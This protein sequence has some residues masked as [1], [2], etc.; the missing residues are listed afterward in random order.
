ML[1]CSKARYY[2]PT[3]G[4]FVSEDPVGYDSWINF[5]AYGE[6]SPVTNTDPS[7]QQ[8][9]PSGHPICYTNC[10]GGNLGDWNTAGEHACQIVN[11]PECQ[12]VL[13]QQ[14]ILGCMRN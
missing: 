4:R 14:S 8:A 12:K 10:P 1:S 5:Y 6:N 2:N 7:G 3:I 11:R 13:G 9:A